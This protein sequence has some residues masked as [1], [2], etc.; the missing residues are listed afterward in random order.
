MGQ[1]F[2]STTRSVAAGTARPAERRADPD[3][4]DTVRTSPVLARRRKSGP[5]ATRSGWLTGVRKHSLVCFTAGGRIGPVVTLPVSGQVVALATTDANVYVNALQPPGSTAPS[6]I[7]S[8][9][10]PAACR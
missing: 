4:A 8:Y 2:A 10:V 5:A 9:P 1:Q 7:V 6:Q 3:D